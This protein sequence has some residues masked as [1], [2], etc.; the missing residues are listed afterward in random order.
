MKSRSGHYFVWFILFGLIAGLVS[1]LGSAHT[2][3]SEA[4]W[5][6]ATGVIGWLLGSKR[7]NTG[8]VA[9]YFDYLVG[10][11][12]MVAGLLGI[13]DSFNSSLLAPIANNAS[14]L[15]SNDTFLGLSLALFPA[16][17]H[18]F[19]GYMS[20]RHGMENSAKS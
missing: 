9:R 12:F 1:F 17:V 11:I 15:M 5:L 14:F 10:I 2:L 20:F 13:V 8:S 4:I 16:V 6:L 3:S 7:L 18:L 19:L